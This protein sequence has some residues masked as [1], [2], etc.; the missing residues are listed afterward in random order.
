MSHCLKENPTR[1]ASKKVEVKVK[2]DTIKFPVLLFLLIEYFHVRTCHLT[3][4]RSLSS[5]SLTGRRQETCVPLLKTKCRQD[6]LS[7]V[8]FP[9]ITRHL[10]EDTTLSGR[11][12]S[13]KNMQPDKLNSH[14]SVSFLFCFFHTWFGLFARTAA[15]FQPGF[16]Y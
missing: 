14:I 6:F 11:K 12:Q 2:A 1:S 15:D 16:V 8:C 13:L 5:S 7:P 4:G 3:G 9:S 10:Q